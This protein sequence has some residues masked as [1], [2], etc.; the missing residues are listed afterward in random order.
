MKGGAHMIS[1]C[2]PYPDGGPDALKPDAYDA[3]GNLTV[4][5]WSLFMQDEIDS[6]NDD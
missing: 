3:E 2:Y 4:N 1:K 6:E 5:S